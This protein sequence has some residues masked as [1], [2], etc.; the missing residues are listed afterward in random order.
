VTDATEPA[1]FSGVHVPTS[2]RYLRRLALASVAAL[3]TVGVS[4]PF[5]SSA[6]AARSDCSKSS[7][8]ASV[9]GLTINQTGLLLERIHDEKG[10][11][12][13]WGDEPARYIEPHRPDLWCVYAR[14]FGAAMKAEYRFPDST[15]VYMEAW[16]YLFQDPGSSCEIR[17]P[18]AA[19][20]MCT[21]RA[22]REGLTQ[23]A[24]AHFTID[25]RRR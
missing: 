13:D 1:A 9:S 23:F 4:L 14:T 8:S 10:I 24:G 12:N 16:K 22:H 18:S 21:H 17:G 19:Q 5:S 3:L 20:F 15:I 6:S 2:R 11:T 25:E 7:V